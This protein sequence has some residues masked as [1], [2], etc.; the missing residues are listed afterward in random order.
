MKKTTFN[1][2]IDDLTNNIGLISQ[3][4]INSLRNKFPYCELVHITAVL[5]AEKEQHINFS[6]LLSI[7]SL[8][9]SSREN[10]YNLINPKQDLKKQKNYE[11]KQNFEN[12]LKNS[13]TKKH[14]GKIDINIKKS[15]QDSDY[16][17][18]ETLAEVYVEQGHYNRAIQ[19]YEIL[20]LKYPKK[21]SFFANRIQYIKN[22][23]F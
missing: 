23:K 15:I 8:Y 3:K 17:T 5:K 19:A 14:Q 18:T 20:C 13:A 6:E 9:S 7:S 16:L 1:K 10:L 21:S 4:E 2:V 12:W 11:T 22:I